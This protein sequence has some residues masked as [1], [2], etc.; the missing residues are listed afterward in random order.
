[1]EIRELLRQPADYFFTPMSPSPLPWRLTRDAFAEVDRRITAMV[2]PPKTE[3][4]VKDGMSFLHSPAATSKT[5]KKLMMLLYVLPT[6]LRGYVRPIRRALRLL[7]LGLRMIDGQAHS[8]NKCIQLGIEPGC[9]CLDP[10]LIPTIK[11]LII[12]GLAMNE[13]SVPPSTIIPCLHNLGHY[14]DHAK[15]FGILRW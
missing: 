11:K 1:M 2:F 13:G 10:R 9:R 15:K 5:K 12:D 8:Y 3:R 7:V 14:A 6:V 4:V